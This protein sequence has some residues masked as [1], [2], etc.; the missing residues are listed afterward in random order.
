MTDSKEL[1]HYIH[2]AG[3][4]ITKLAQQ[5]YISTDTLIAKLNGEQEFYVDEIETLC[6]ILNIPISRRRYIFFD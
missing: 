1:L 3:V 2:Q 4:S 5:L 6:I